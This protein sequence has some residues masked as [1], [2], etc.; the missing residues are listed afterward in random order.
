MKLTMRN[1]AA[2]SIATVAVM[3]S[4]AVSTGVGAASAAAPS[5]LTDAQ[6]DHKSE[7]KPAPSLLSG[8]KHGTTWPIYSY[9]EV[10]WYDTFGGIDL[11][12]LALSDDVFPVGYS[13]KMTVTFGSWKKSVH[14]YG[15]DSLM[16]D[17]PGLHAGDEAKFKACAWDDGDVVPGSCVTGTVTE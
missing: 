12:S 3:A 4:W 14:A 6:Q 2:V 7:P 13:V 17:I 16:V 8:T 15:G 1:R 11:D 10:K 9:G 5:A